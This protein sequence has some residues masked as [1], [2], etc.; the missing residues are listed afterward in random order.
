MNWEPT[1]D[2]YRKM[3]RVARRKAFKFVTRNDDID[4]VAKDI[5]QDAWETFIV[6][7]L[8][9]KDIDSCWYR[10]F[11]RMAQKHFKSRRPVSTVDVDETPLKSLDPTVEDLVIGR[12][13]MT[14]FEEALG[15]LR[16]N[17]KC[18]QLLQ[19]MILNEGPHIVGRDQCR[20][21]EPRRRQRLRKMY[22]EVVN[23]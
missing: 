8:T 1:D 23:G 17:D 21:D 11:S 12:Q 18:L 10:A 20:G 19:Q 14:R 6:T 16:R 4:D 9:G 13:M 7:R 5:E 2:D 15:K 22:Q 3:R